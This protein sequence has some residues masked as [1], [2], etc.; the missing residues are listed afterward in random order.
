MTIRNQDVKVNR[1]DSYVVFVALTN[2]DGTPYDPASAVVMKWRMVDTSHDLDINAH[3]RKDLGS[4][5]DIVTS[6]V[7][8]ANITLSKTDTDLPPGNYYHELKAWDVNDVTTTTSGAFIVRHAIQMTRENLVS[9]SAQNLTLTPV[10]P[11]V[12]KTGS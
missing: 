12:A 1:G 6:P 7:K 8:G 9:P 11:T 3:I 10:A 5:I 2:A 4:G